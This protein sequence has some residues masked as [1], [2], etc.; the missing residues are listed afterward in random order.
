MKCLGV[1]CKQRLR[2]LLFIVTIVSVTCV[3]LIVRRRR[4]EKL[5]DY[6]FMKE[7]NRF[8][9]DKRYVEDSKEELDIDE[10][11]AGKYIPPRRVVHID[12]KGA[13]P[14]LPYLISTLP[15]LV[16]AG[17]TDLL[18]EYEDMFPFSGHL[19]NVSSR[20]ALSRAEISSLVQAAKDNGLKVIP[21]VQTFGH[22]EWLLKLERFKHLRESPHYPESICPSQEETMDILRT[23]LMQVMEMHPDSKHIHIGCD[24]VFHIG[25]CSQCVQRINNAN[26]HNE[27][28]SYY[29]NRMLFLEH[30]KAVAGFVNRKGKDQSE[31]SIHVT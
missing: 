16:K 9:W 24:E 30:V 21:L 12:M 5:T 14:R 23:M 31:A 27:G 3:F 4:H 2:L 26:L 7:E 22:M 28:S 19:R 6:T 17:A 11:R 13:P 1:C 18:L 29:S 20:L 25:E 10:I 8:F 15:L